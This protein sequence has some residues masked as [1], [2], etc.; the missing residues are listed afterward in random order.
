MIT[1]PFAR[2]LRRRDP[3]LGEASKWAVEASFP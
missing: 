2:R 3:V 1:L